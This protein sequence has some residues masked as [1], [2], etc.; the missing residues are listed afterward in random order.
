MTPT[1]ARPVH[2]CS[3]C[4]ARHVS[5]ENHSDA[6]CV[7]MLES[8]IALLETSIADEKRQTAEIEADIRGRI[9]EFRKVSDATHD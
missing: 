5:A 8:R 2:V 3:E 1:T 4:D 7:E 9:L 6:D